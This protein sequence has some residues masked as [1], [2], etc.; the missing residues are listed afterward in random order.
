MEWLNLILSH[1]LLFFLRI[2]TSDNDTQKCV[3]P[4]SLITFQIMFQVKTF[5]AGVILGVKYF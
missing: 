2:M 1:R 3:S 5:I 4:P